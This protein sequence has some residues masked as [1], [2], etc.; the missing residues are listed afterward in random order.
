MTIDSGQGR[1]QASQATEERSSH[2]LHRDS[3]RSAACSSHCSQR[4]R[5]IG[6]SSPAARP[7]ISSARGRIQIYR[8]RCGDLVHPHV[9]RVDPGRSPHLYKPVLHHADYV[10]GNGADTRIAFGALLEVILAIANIATAVVLF[11]VLRKVK[12][13]VAL[14]YVASRTL[15][16]TVIVIGLISLMSV[17]TLRQDFADK[18]ADP[19]SFTIA[20]RLL[21]AVHDGTFLLGPAFCAGLGNGLLLGYLMYKSGLV[22]RRMARVGLIGGSLALVT[23][24]AVLF[25]AWGQTSS[26][27]FLFTLPEIV[28]EA[29]LGIYLTFW[30][31]RPAGVAGLDNP[32]VRVAGVPVGSAAQPG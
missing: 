1:W 13:S 19:A 21:V 32:E 10:L 5:R 27:S 6:C 7:G 11:P 26:V 15:E 9:C 2:E 28:W 23:A 4:Q 17:V 31:F 8:P 16:S 18:G 3:Y 24:V 30:G 29:F 12:E 20:G 22:P 14:G 25:G